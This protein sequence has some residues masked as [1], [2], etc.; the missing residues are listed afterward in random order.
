MY[1]TQCLKRK[2][3]KSFVLLTFLHL[4][5]HPNSGPLAR[6]HAAE[7]SSRAEITCAPEMKGRT[8]FKSPL[9][10]NHVSDASSSAGAGATH[11]L[12]QVWRGR[13]VCQCSLISSG[14][15][16]GG[17]PPLVDSINLVPG[18]NF[19]VAG[20]ASSALTPTPSFYL[21]LSS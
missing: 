6:G 7:V 4:S 15:P 16:K 5:P 17:R 8:L 12:Y 3:E 13:N 10:S 19:F 20:G 18:R 11:R 1:S 9:P 14:V 2:E 21:C